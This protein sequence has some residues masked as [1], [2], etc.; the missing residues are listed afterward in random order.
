MK[1]YVTLLIN[2]SYV[3]GALVLGH[4]LRKTGTKHKLAILMDSSTVSPN[5]QDL[6]K[7]VYDDVIEI[8]DKKIFMPIDLV[9]KKL[10][11][12]QLAVSLTKI[13]IW[14][15]HQYDHVI[16]LDADTIP[17]K[18]LDHLFERYASQKSTEIV[19]APD[20]GWPD[21]FNS[22]V[23]IV[24]PD[25]AVFEFI[26]EY[27][28]KEQ[29][30]YDGADQGLL[31]EVFHL[32]GHEGFKW[33]RLPFI[34]NMSPSSL[35]QSSPATERF[36]HEIH[37]VHFVG[38]GKPWLCSAVLSSMF[39]DI[40]WK[41]FNEAHLEKERI[42]VLSRRPNDGFSLKNKEGAT[43]LTETSIASAFNA[44]NVREAAKVFPWEHRK[45]VEAS[46][47]FE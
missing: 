4:S 2:E 18:S 23:M 31:N 13:L 27:S 1:A 7:R 36:L 22:G 33:T 30:S 17:I 37:L 6:L 46:R 40:W 26:K 29:A 45:P 8:N 41:A 20:I 32:Q 34:Y 43:F 25:P 47:V 21:V 19:S 16:Y 3:P 11:R 39:H 5:S 14:Q 12:P 35:Y 15:L 24:K 44:L 42:H 38:S 28:E 10:G 9:T